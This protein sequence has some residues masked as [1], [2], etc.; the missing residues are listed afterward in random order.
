ME[1]LN[2][3]KKGVKLV[4]SAWAIDSIE[5]G[6]RLSERKY[7]P[8]VNE[9]GIHS[10]WDRTHS[11]VRLMNLSDPGST[12]ASIYDER[13]SASETTSACSRL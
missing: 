1:A 11:I 10:P 7:S 2:R 5:A 3:Q 8:A 13:F 12:F 4:T 9:V 6:K